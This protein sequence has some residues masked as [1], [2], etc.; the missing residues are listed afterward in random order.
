MK[1]LCAILLSV[2]LGLTSATA[3]GNAD[4]AKAAQAVKN[5]DDSRKVAG[6]VLGNNTVTTGTVIGAATAGVI[7]AAVANGSNKSNHSH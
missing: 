3:A 6:L 5:A 2:S 1:K 7:A 4:A